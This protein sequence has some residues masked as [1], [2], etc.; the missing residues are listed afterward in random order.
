M[1]TIDI[2]KDSV[3]HIDEIVF[4]EN[5]A[6]TPDNGTVDIKCKQG[7]YTQGSFYCVECKE[8]AE[9]LIKALQKALELGWFDD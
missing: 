6:L 5:C 4:Y 7:Y 9:D 2:R 8:E 3:E 1:T